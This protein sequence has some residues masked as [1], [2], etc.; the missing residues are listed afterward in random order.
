M[1]NAGGE[2][3]QNSGGNNNNFVHRIT[4]SWNA[5]SAFPLNKELSEH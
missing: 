5:V 3:E 2:E 4:Y 1:L